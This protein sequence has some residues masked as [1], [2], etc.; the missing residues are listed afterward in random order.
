MS[1]SYF[2]RYEG[3]AENPAAFMNYYRH[4]HAP[5]LARWP[6]I[7][8]LVLHQPL[9]SQD[10]FPVNAD[11]FSLLVQMVFDNSADLEAALQSPERGEARQDFAHFPTFQGSVF[12]QA[13]EAEELAIP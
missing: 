3:R 1:V 11:C 12:H 13:A 4:H 2:V 7:R 5:I 8:R 6:G 10:P 9:N